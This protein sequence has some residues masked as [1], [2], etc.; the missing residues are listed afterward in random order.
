MIRSGSKG[1]SEQQSVTTESGEE[2]AA[3]RRFGRARIVLPFVF[4]VA[5]AIA[6]WREVSAIDLLHVRETLRLIPLGP[7]L[8]IQALALLAILAMTPY[9]LLIAPVLG[10][11]R[12]WRAWVHDAWIA[13]TFNNMVGLAG[14]TGSGLR[15][16]LAGRGGLSHRQAANQA[17]LVMLT[18][19]AGLSVLAWPLWI[20]GAADGTWLSGSAL[21]VA[22]AYLPLYLLLTGDGWLHRRF[23][24]N[25][26]V[27]SRQRQALL[28][29][30]SIID[31]LLA[32]LTL[33]LC[34]SVAGVD[35]PPIQVVTAFVTAALAGIISML[36]GGA[37]VFDGVLFLL[38][39]MQGTNSE[40]LVAGIVI[41]RVVYY[42]VPWLIGI[43]LG[44]AVLTSHENAPL[45]TLQHYW[46]SSPLLAPLRLPL[47]LFSAIVVRALAY[48]TFAAGAVLLFSSALPESQLGGWPFSQTK[49][50]LVEGLHLGGVF[51][52]VMLIIL[53]GGVVRQVEQVYRMVIPALLCGA[54]LVLLKDF[55]YALAGFLVALAGLLR[56][57]RRR[58]YRKAYP[59]NSWRT[60]RWLLAMLV[61]LGLYAALGHLVYDNVWQA[62][63]LHWS[64]SATVHAEQFLRSLLL[65]PL[66][67]LGILGW[68]FFRLPRP[69][70]NRPDSTALAAAYAFLNRFGGSSFAHL[71]L[72][73]DKQLFYAEENR[74]LIPYAPIRNRLVALGD[75]AGDSRLFRGAIEEFYSLADQHDLEP[76][77]YEVSEAY[78]GL[79]HDLGF[80]LFKLGE[81][82]LV[83]TAGFTL[84]GKRRESLRHSVKQA[85]RAGV[86]FEVP[87]HPLSEAQWQELQAVSDAWL[88]SRHTP[89]KGFSLGRFDRDYLE[90]SPLALVRQDQEVVAFASLM[91]GYGSRRQ[92]AVDLMRSLSTAPKGTMDFMFVN[93][94][95]YA[96][97]TGYEYFDMGVAPLS[98]VGQSR[99]APVPERAA[100][101]AFEHG[102][103]FYSYKGLR[104]F[105]AKYGPQWQ[106][107]YLAYRPRT[108]LPALLLDIAALI[109]GGYRK[110]LLARPG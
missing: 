4:L 38:L 59:V 47:V 6:G 62:D 23:L 45:S 56:L 95:A 14:L 22:A 15:Y 10:V 19:P 43:Y 83:S 97:E 93:L 70:R 81:R 39:H 44:G 52:G 98:N 71:L 89:E 78:L 11:R 65:L 13:N 50:L 76:V 94:I 104:S 33:W 68:L 73:G 1:T 108:P 40:E 82:A 91:P 8:G 99:Y 31:W 17:A 25:L 72:A 90:R 110:L 96:R 86:S 51:V 77:F 57:Q 36:P 75:P 29:G 18:I 16:L 20:S 80:R 27:F 87:D 30:V 21:A 7:V 79:F 54:L 3:T 46:N 74:V 12:S 69:D 60:A 37:G 34:I 64:A 109:A 26:P 35:T 42:L 53:A 85:E 92:L 48:L 88:Q 55:H 32:A 103:R 67:A 28:V 58:F 5:T 101:L 84:S 41:F 106:G 9:D 49:A 2:V 102:S 66:F 63:A 105:K 100:R 24:G 61:S 107:V